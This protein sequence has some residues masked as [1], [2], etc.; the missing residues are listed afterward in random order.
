MKRLSLIYFTLFLV[1]FVFTFKSLIANISTDLPDWLDYALVNWIITENIQ[2]IQSLNFANFF[3][4]RAF[5]PHKNTLFFADTFLPQTLLGL[6]FSLFTK[7]IV[8][9]FNIIFIQTFIL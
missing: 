5:Y 9:V 2:K 4:T 7:N 3:D 6:P 1:I 8:L